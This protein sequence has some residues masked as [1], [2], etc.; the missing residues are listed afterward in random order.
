MEEES[1]F[2]LRPE[3]LDRLLSI[4]T[5]GEPAEIKAHDAGAEGA[6][7]KVAFG[8]NPGPSEKDP[9]SKA[10]LSLSAMVEQPGGW[11]ERYKLLSVLGE[12]G[13]GIVY[14][15]EQQEPIKRQVALKVIKPGMD[16]KRVIARFEAERQTLALLDHPN[17]A[18][19][20]DAGMTE[21]GRPYFVMEHVKG[22]P[23]TEHC[24]RHKLT[25]VQRLK[26]FQQVCWAI[27]HAHQRGILHRD[28]KPSNILVSMEGDRA[29]PK[30]IDFGVAKALAQPLTERTLATEDS[31][32][33]GTPEYMS[34]EQA[35]MATE[36]IDIRSDIYSLG[37]LLYVLLTGVLPFDSDTLRTGGIE[38]IRKTIRE[39]DPKTPSTRL[40]KLG[41][42][43]QKVAE[44]RRTKIGTLAKHLRKELEWIP[45]KAM[46]KKRAERYRSVVELADDIENYLIGAP[47]LAGP[48]TAQY[49]IR[50]FVRRNKN[51][52]TAG[53][54]VAAALV[55][56]LAVSVVLLVREQHARRQAQANE[57]AMRQVAYASDMRM[58]QHAL[59][60]NDM[61]R[62]RGLLEAY[63]PTPGEDD[64]RGW[65]WRYLWNEIRSDTIGE[66]CQYPNSVVSMAYSPNGRMLA[67]NGNTVDIWDVSGR[68]LIRH[69]QPTKS[70]C[71]AFSSRGDLLATEG[72][73]NGVR[74]IRL[75]RTDT[76]DR[77]DRGQ[78]TLDDNNASFKALQFSPDGTRL[79]SLIDTPSTHRKD[80]VTV[81]D[82]D[83]LT[84]VHEN[85]DVELEVVFGDLSFSPDGKALAV[86]DQRG[87][88][89]VI[90]LARRK[91]IH[92]P[93]EAHPEG[94]VSVAWSP[95]G[96]VIAS[97]SGWVG[98]PIRLWD[99]VSGK[100][101]GDLKGHTSW[102]TDLVFS[103]DGRWLYSSSGDQTIRVWDVEQRQCL[104][105]VRGCNHEVL[106]L[107]LS[108]DGSTLASACKDGV[109]ALW[110]A[111]PEQKEEMPRRIPL[112]EFAYFAFSPDS[113]ELAVPQ[114]GTVSLYDLT[115][116]QKPEQI[117]ELD[118]NVAVVAY[119][120][121]GALLVSGSK[122][123]EICVW[124]RAKRCVL[125]KWNRHNSRIL[126]LRFRADGER[127]LSFDW[128]RNMIWWDTHTWKEARSFKVE[129]L[130]HWVRYDHLRRWDISPD[131]RLLTIAIKGGLRWLN[132]ET[133]VI[134]KETTGSQMDQAWGVAFSSD[135]LQVASAYT[136]GTV[137]LCDATTFELVTSFRGHL[138]GAHGAAFSP[139][140]RRLVTTGTSLDA[141]R[142]WDLSTRRE[143]LALSGTSSMLQF[144]T[145][146]PD[147]NWL[148]ASDRKED[149]LQL[150]RVPSWEE[151]EA[152]EKRFQNAQSP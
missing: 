106:G 93:W 7:S 32:L 31:H 88:L 28:I 103:K 20:Y 82:I 119:S 43:A 1:V 51:I 46:Q 77:I 41:D 60:M 107:A 129:K 63:R 136:Y 59:E 35:D 48:L 137:A 13:M 30:I 148:A 76:W 83:Q 47:L 34:P 45:L 4:G 144:V 52:F 147:G 24:D 37:V 78:L 87:R 125:K 10:T 18:H 100:S 66:L 126:M 120:P 96:S 55:I 8:D 89:Q 94:I 49:R 123:G 71:V 90:D 69:L 2:G 85:F 121:D 128:Q 138:L 104:T 131:G 38:H 132:A 3:Q 98:G 99:P 113:R 124:S 16:S 86:G 5:D 91:T 115:T 79:A 75:W 58:A 122:K 40:T 105:T 133:G 21:T 112:D 22:L 67:V 80:R 17:I 53:A 33:L 73:T 97:G 141:V 102:I 81:W 57:L 26:L 56:G 130:P 15:A 64:L 39:T 143:L 118:P 84:V 44:N 65:E 27:Q 54:M 101:L 36:D 151:I 95:K 117:P 149:M 62:V 61:A 114:A 92:D 19:V 25:V 11:I 110:N 152:E 142:L 145:F 116:Y 109:V 135:G 42:E 68:K 9:P 12:G 70:H 139:D 72:A 111:I 150:W 146:S 23:I 74:Q 14:L 127:L 29:V 140:S 134:L 50:K 108:P 6:T